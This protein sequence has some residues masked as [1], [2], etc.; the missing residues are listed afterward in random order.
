MLWAA[1]A[2]GAALCAA[3]IRGGLPCGGWWRPW[4]SLS[5]HGISREGA[6]GW[7]FL[8]RWALSFGVGALSIQLRNGR[9]PHDDELLVFATGEDVV[10][11]AH[12]IHGGE[13]RLAGFGGLRQSID[14]ETEEIATDQQ[15]QTARGGMRVS[16]YAKEPEQEY[17]EGDA[18]PM[19][20][21]LGNF[22]PRELWVGGLPET[23]AIVALLT[24]AKS[25]GI[26]VVRHSEGENFEFGGARVAVLSPPADWRTSSQPKN[27]DSLVL[28]V[29]FHESSV[30]LEGDAE[31][32][33][34]QR[35]TASE[36]RKSD[37]LK[38]G[39]H[40]SANS[41]SAEFI[42]AVRP[43]WAIISVGATNTFGHPRRETLEHLQQ[44]GVFTYRTDRNGAVTFYLDGKSV[45][46]QL[47]CLR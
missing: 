25:L 21:V 38:V 10:V 8:S 17:D 14:V 47:A 12:V 46:P 39:H 32:P 41:S 40:G 23:P 11:T 5:R 33:V 2:Y 7:D 37:L 30:L 22:R 6:G 13:T 4:P 9:P 42:H 34:E 18:V 27:N 19:H 43:R 28:R 29:S 24:H 20:A 1:L 36:D 35:M 31:K 44:E 16:I 26:Q 15:M 45:S 3:C